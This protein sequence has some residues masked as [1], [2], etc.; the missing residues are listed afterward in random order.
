M[1]RIKKIVIDISAVCDHRYAY[2]DNFHLLPLLG[3]I[4]NG[5]LSC[6]E[7]TFAHTGRRTGGGPWV[8]T[9]QMLRATAIRLNKALVSFTKDDTLERR[10]LSA[11][12]SFLSSLSMTSNG[13]GGSVQYYTALRSIVRDFGIDRASGKIVWY[14]AKPITSPTDLPLHMQDV[15]CRHVFTPEQSLRVVLNSFNPLSCERSV[16]DVSLT[17]R[18]CFTRAVRACTPVTIELKA[19]EADTNYNV[20]DPSRRFSLDTRALRS[21][22]SRG[23]GFSPCVR[24]PQCGGLISHVIKQSVEILHGEEQQT[25]ET[26]LLVR[27]SLDRP[28]QPTDVRIDTNDLLY[29]LGTVRHESIKEKVFLTIQ[30]EY[31]EGGEATLRE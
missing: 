10:Y 2:S 3:I 4:W 5:H 9:P 8:K 24:L 28:T 11:S 17:F 6:C 16:F 27:I 25:T 7:I 22:R 20:L 1:K 21:C 19:A 15:I 13:T 30:L 31:S 12:R 29:W 23:W 18:K 14:T 26:T